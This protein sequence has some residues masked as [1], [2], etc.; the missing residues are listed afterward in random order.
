MY[1]KALLRGSKRTTRADLIE[2]PAQPISLPAT[3]VM[4]SLPVPRVLDHASRNPPRQDSPDPFPTVEEL[5]D[6][7]KYRIAKYTTEENVS[8]RKFQFCFTILGDY[9]KVFDPIECV[10]PVVDGRAPRVIIHPCR[11]YERD[12][13]NGCTLFST[14]KRLSEKHDVLCESCRKKK[15][16]AIR[17]TKAN[18][19][20]VNRDARTAPSSKVRIDCL[21]P[22]ET[23]TRLKRVIIKNKGLSQR[24]KHGL[25]SAKQM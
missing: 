4:V 9:H 5:R 15:D 10:G 16:A 12:V 11:G 24:V 20:G 21:T 25:H 22:D 6:V 17:H 7:V 2:T 8:N 18:A 19:D 14:R 23:R 3:P 1:V 13:S